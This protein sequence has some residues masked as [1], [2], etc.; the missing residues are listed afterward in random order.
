VL[1]FL[2]ELLVNVYAAFLSDFIVGAGHH[3]V[4][5]MFKISSGPHLIKWWDN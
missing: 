4:D 5:S 3:S 1:F 2:T